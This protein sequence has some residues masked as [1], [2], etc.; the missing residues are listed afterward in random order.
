MPGLPGFY[1]WCIL[2]VHNGRFFFTLVVQVANWDHRIAQC[3]TDH[4]TNKT[5]Y[6]CDTD[7]CMLSARPHS[8]VYTHSS[9][10][11]NTSTASL[12]SSLFRILSVI[13][14]FRT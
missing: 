4:D 13:R 8:P 6:A 5:M 11:T 1:D 2:A 9:L 10:R 3:L 14:E 12:F 7:S